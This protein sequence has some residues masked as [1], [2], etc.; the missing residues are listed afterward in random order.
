MLFMLPIEIAYYEKGN[1]LPIILKMNL[2]EKE[3]TQ[4]FTIKGEVEKVELDPRNVLLSENV[5]LKI[6]LVIFPKEILHR[7]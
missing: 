2:S 1:A 3:K 4:T 6:K 5:F 7:F